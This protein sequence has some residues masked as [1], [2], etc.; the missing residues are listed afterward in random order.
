MRGAEYRVGSSRVAPDYV[1]LKDFL[2]ACVMSSELGF[3]VV[4]GAAGF[5]E[6]ALGRLWLRPSGSWG[7]SGEAMASATAASESTK[8][9]TVPEPAREHLYIDMSQWG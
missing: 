2:L 8:P 7:G 3:L 6:V 5:G 9:R 4:L 1:A